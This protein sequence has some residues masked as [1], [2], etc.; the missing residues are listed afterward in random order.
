MFYV[1]NIEDFHRKARK[2]LNE[3]DFLCAMKDVGTEL[4]RLRRIRLRR[5]LRLISFTLTFIWCADKL[6]R[7]ALCF[8][9]YYCFIAYFFL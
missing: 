9:K 4:I 8:L 1:L 2:K 5:K 7:R 6:K 3:K